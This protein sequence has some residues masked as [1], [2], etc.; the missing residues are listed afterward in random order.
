MPFPWIV[1]ILLLLPA[2][3][4]YLIFDWL[5]S[6]PLWALLYLAATVTG[7]LFLIKLAKVGF[8]ESLAKLK[9]DSFSLSAIPIFGKLWVVGTL[10]AFPGYITD[11]LALVVLLWPI[12]RSP[13]NGG[14]KDS[15]GIMEIEGRVIE[16][17]DEESRQSR[18]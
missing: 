11:L 6:A 1:F 14:G 7:G 12:A 10:L 4:V 13:N 9:S 16:E 8:A 18:D 15:S 5:L 2:V 3:E 17:T